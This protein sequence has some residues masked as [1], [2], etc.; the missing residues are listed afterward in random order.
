MTNDDVLCAFLSSIVT[1][2]R[3]SVG[4]LRVVLAEDL[5]REV[6]VGGARL[7]V[8]AVRDEVEGL[9]AQ[10]RVEEMLGEA[11]RSI[12]VDVLHLLLRRPLLQAVGDLIGRRARG[13]AR[14]EGQHEGR[15][16]QGQQQRV[17]RS[18]L[19]RSRYAVVHARGEKI[20]VDGRR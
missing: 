5:R 20:P 16:G 1:C 13:A 7:L 4:A 11:G 19:M 17:L 6:A 15:H 9:V 12:R 3:F 14:G 18:T 8:L 2:A 10:V